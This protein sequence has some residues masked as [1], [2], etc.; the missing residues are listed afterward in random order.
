M[1]KYLFELSA[2]S[3]VYYMGESYIGHLFL[4]QA[5]E[6]GVVCIIQC[7]KGIGYYQ[8]EPGYGAPPRFM[9]LAEK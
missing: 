1:I 5:A 4:E 9:L 3:D 6:I 8:G 7:G 2:A